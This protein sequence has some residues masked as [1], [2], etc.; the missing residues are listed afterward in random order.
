MARKL[1]KDKLTRVDYGN[2]VT[3][4]TPA[5]KGMFFFSGTG[6]AGATCNGCTAALDATP[7]DING[8]PTGAMKVRCKKTADYQGGSSAAFSPDAC[9]CKYFQRRPK[10]LL[11]TAFDKFNGA[12]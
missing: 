1:S 4:D 6:P 9:A 10:P 8:N 5:V 12:K 3:D 2:G 7:R 11:T